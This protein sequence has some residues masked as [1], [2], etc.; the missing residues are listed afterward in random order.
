MGARAV[1]WPDL[2][3]DGGSRAARRDFQQIRV[4]AIEEFFALKGHVW[5]ALDWASLGAVYCDGPAPDF[6]DEE[7]RAAIADIGLAAAVELTGQLP[8]GGKSLYVGAGVAEVLAVCVEALL[9]ERFVQIT[10]LP[11]F[12]PRELDRVLG[13]TAHALPRFSGPA[14]DEAQF[15]GPFDHVWIASVFNDPDAFP[16]LHDHLYE[17]FTEADGATG[18][19]LV[20]EDR[21][22]ATAWMERLE[23]ELAP[24]AVLSTSDEEWSLWEPFLKQRGWR[25][26][27]VDE[28]HVSAL[29]GDRVR[30]YRLRKAEAARG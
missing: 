5:A 27:A 18:R 24:V 15:D 4:K 28:G 12:E 9:A 23:G 17:R 14:F 16:A 20:A 1:G 11:G 22:R 2:I 29:V 19:G 3:K 10:T 30:M 26:T 13:A 6:F 7:R 25:T 8:V 21:A